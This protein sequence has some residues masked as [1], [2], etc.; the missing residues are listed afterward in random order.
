M[1]IW[2]RDISDAVLRDKIV[3]QLKAGVPLNMVRKLSTGE[4]EGWLDDA[5][6]LVGQ[7]DIMAAALVLAQDDVNL[8][9]VDRHVYIDHDLELLQLQLA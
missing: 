2:K 9:E 3:T 6:T 7:D 5:Q 8:V 1:A 4:F